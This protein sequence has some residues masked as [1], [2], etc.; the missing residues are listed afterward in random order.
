MITKENTNF[1]IADQKV[2]KQEGTDRSELPL[3]LAPAIYS[4][5]EGEKYVSIYSLMLNEPFLWIGTERGLIKFDT[6]TNTQKLYST[7][8]GL[9]TNNVTGYA[10]GENSIWILTDWGGL[11]NI[12]L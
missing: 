1:V 6:Q 11:S 5:F 10:I 12:P 2:Y 9:L 4:P 7:R 8:N 3:A